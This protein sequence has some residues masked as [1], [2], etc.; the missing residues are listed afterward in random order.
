M[1]SSVD[2]ELSGQL[3]DDLMACCR[4]GSTPSL[5][6]LCRQHPQHADNRAGLDQWKA[7]VLAGY[8]PRARTG[9]REGSTVGGG[10]G[11]TTDVPV[12]HP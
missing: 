6:E 11:R 9:S 7:G 1:T 5:E 2:E 4:S 8:L 12:A 10:R 3:L